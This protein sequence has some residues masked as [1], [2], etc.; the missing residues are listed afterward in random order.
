MAV[1]AHC[2][3][4]ATADMCFLSH[5]TGPSQQPMYRGLSLTPALTC[6]KPATLTY[7]LQAFLSS[8]FQNV[9]FPSALTFSVPLVQHSLR[10]PL[11]NRREVTG[12]KKCPSWAGNPRD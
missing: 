8:G 3:E 9:L 10:L 5:S 11:A 12:R 4:T 6:P 1:G 7:Q 2:L